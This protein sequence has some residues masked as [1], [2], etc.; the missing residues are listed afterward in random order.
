MIKKKFKQKRSQKRINEI[1]EKYNIPRAYLAINRK[2]ISKG[3]FLGLFIAFIPMPM[4]MLTVILF[5]PFFRFNVPI[6][7]SMVWLTNP[8]TMPFIYYLEYKTGNFILNKN[9]LEGIE[10]T[11]E[12]FSQNWDNII[13][14]LYVGTIPYSLFIPTIAY[15]FINQL[16]ITSIKKEKLKNKS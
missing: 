1:V 14:P 10:L 2:S 16:W 15:V 9:S 3:V 11:L 4:Q 5:T 13:L 12:W 7:I 8:I 6:A